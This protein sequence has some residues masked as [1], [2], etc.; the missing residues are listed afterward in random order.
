MYTY[1][2]SMYHVIY[3]QPYNVLPKIAIGDLIFSGTCTTFNGIETAE[4]K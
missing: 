2:T 3:K 4:S 1:K